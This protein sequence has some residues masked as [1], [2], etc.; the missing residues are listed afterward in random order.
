MLG[1]PLD[2]MVGGFPSE[3]VARMRTVL[4]EHGHRTQGPIGEERELL[5]STSGYDAAVFLLCRTDQSPGA[6][7]KL[8]ETVTGQ[9]AALTTLLGRERV[10]LAYGPDVEPL[11]GF[12][13]ASSLVLAEDF[14]ETSSV[15]AV[16]LSLQGRLS[17]WRSDGIDGAERDD[18]GLRRPLLHELR[19]SEIN[20]R[21]L[22]AFFSSGEQRAEPFTLNS[23][24]ACISAYC[25]ALERVER[26]FRTTTYL[27]SGFWTEGDPGILESND[28]VNR[29]LAQNGGLVQRVL[30][31]ERPPKQEIAWW[32]DEYLRRRKYHDRDGCRELREKFTR[33][34][35]AMRALAAGGCSIRMVHAEK[36]GAPPPWLSARGGHEAELAI[37]DDWRVD[38]FRVAHRQTIT[39]LESYTHAFEGFPDLR[40][41]LEEYFDVLWE[42]GSPLD[43]FLDKLTESFES[44]GARIDYAPTW[45]ARYDFGLPPEDEAL[46]IVEL[47]RVREILRATGR[48]GAIGNYLDIGTCTARYPLNLRQAVRSDGRIIGLDSDIDSVRFARSRVMQ[49]VGP[50]DRIRIE[51]GDFCDAD[52][53][54]D[55]RFDLITCMLGTLCHFGVQ[56]S[57]ELP[58]EDVLQ[59]ALERLERLLED[60]GFLFFTVWSEEACRERRLLS[61][62]TDAEA[63]QVIAWTPARA[64]MNARLRRAG[65]SFQGPY[66]LE[67]RLDLYH[68][69]RAETR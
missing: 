9:A 54:F 41:R 61:I 4:E 17:G 63:D 66:R 56:R 47:S 59:A 28:R 51:L 34:C 14:R 19:D 52:L 13:P 39:R 26:K 32:H 10:L 21:A 68:C 1:K 27:S 22:G 24:R 60:Q 57:K 33:L 36:I 35:G 40:K 50:T 20:A 69:Q 49:E 11:A 44:A 30:L 58:Y 5:R 38:I 2:I 55:S 64:E 16:V 53:R 46:K 37:Y 3:S 67:E 45:L 43:A 65:L 15:E 12:S 18:L 7:C 29:R 23:E 8:R 62:Y 48:W 31:L 42:Q 6:L 25:E